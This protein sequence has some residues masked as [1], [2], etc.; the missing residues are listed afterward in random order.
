M[1]FCCQRAVPSSPRSSCQSRHRNEHESKRHRSSG[2][3]VRRRAW[4]DR[5]RET[6]QLMAAATE[7][8]PEG[9]PSC[10]RTRW[11]WSDD[12]RCMKKKKKKK[13]SLWRKTTCLKHP[14]ERRHQLIAH[15]LRECPQ[16]VVTFFLQPLL[17][18]QSEVY[19]KHG[20]EATSLFQPSQDPK[21]TKRSA[22]HARVHRTERTPTSCPICQ[23]GVYAGVQSLKG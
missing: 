12:V 23:D 22:E 7:R 8:P 18:I 20:V 21:C 17:G 6:W 9:H 19:T 1:L 14:S 11:T 5:R 15:Q 3:D 13:W 16:S 4:G 2:H 10:F